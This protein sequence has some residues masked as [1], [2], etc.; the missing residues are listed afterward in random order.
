MAP[1]RATFES[2]VHIDVGPRGTRR[3]FETGLR[4]AIRS[5]RLT[6]GTRLPSSRSLARDIGLSRTGVADAYAQLVAEG[7]LVARAGSCTRVAHP[8]SDDDRVR[9]GARRRRPALPLDLR[10]GRPDP[11]SFPRRAWVSALDEALDR[12]APSALGYAGLRGRPELREVLTDYLARTRGVRTDPSRIV[13]CAG[14]SHGIRMVCA[15]LRGSRGA[16]TVAVE[17]Y[18]LWIHR[19]TVRDTGLDLTG[20]QVDAE[21]ADVT[22]LPGADA[23]LT[24]PA[25]QYPTGVPMSARRRGEVLDWAVRH[26]ALIIEDDYDGE[27]RY[28][29]RSVGAVQPHDPERVVYVGTTSKSL[30]PG[31]RLGWLVLPSHLVREVAR[32]HTVQDGHGSSLDQLALA[33]LLASGEYDRHVRRRRRAYRR[34][35]DRIEAVLRR[36]VPEVELAGADA[37]LHALLRLPPSCVESEIVDLAARHG[38]ALEGLATC[39]VSPHS[40]NAPCLVIGYGAPAERDF[41][42]TVEV[43]VEVLHLHLDR[44]GRAGSDDR[45]SSEVAHAAQPSA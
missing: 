6:P 14:A 1:G 36:L 22:G 38:L 13:I 29:R 9:P 44:V 24:T 32:V 18:G 31:L 42:R 17:E 10:P 19:D 37:G 8:L 5:G 34:R 3:S 16:R 30:A 27:F 43:L 12:A 7:W 41:E 45:A 4:Q 40:T 39:G 33:R 23:L 2:D 35:R 26:D 25:N 15:A 11:T 20:A 28:D 21:G